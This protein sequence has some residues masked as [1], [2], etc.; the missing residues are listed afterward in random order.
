M[1]SSC[2]GRCG[3]LFLA[4]LLGTPGIGAEAPAG[5][6]VEL[7]KFVVQ[8][9]IPL[10]PPESW[11][12]A[13]GD[14]Y[15]V[16]SQ[17]SKRWTGQMVKEFLLFREVMGVVFPG[18]ESRP[19][20]P[21][22]FIFCGTRQFA[23]LAPEEKGAPDVRTLH[24]GAGPE[25]A[26]LIVDPMAFVRSAEAVAL[27]PRTWPLSQESLEIDYFR[28]LRRAYLFALFAQQEPRLPAWF[29]EGLAQLVMGMDYDQ[30]RITFGELEEPTVDLAPEKLI[31]TEGDRMEPL[32]R[33]PQAVSV[34]DRDF[35]IALREY[36]LQPLPVIFAM[37]RESPA[38]R[39][40]YGNAWGKQAAAFVHLGLYGQGRRFQKGFLQ[41]LQRS[42][43]VA[44]TEELFRECFGM[45]YDQMLKELRIYISAPVYD[46]FDYKAKDA[47]LAAPKEVALREATPGEIGRIKGETM[48]LAG[49]DDAGR[50]E[51]IAAYARGSRDPQLLA[52]L[53]LM[54]LELDHAERARRFLEAAFSAKAVRA[55]AQVELARLRLAETVAKPA[56]DGKLSGEQAAFVR[57]PLL[58]ARTQPEPPVAT[59]ELFADVWDRAQE[60]PTPS[61]LVLLEEGVKLY[62]QRLSL[63]YR[64]AV[65]EIRL[66]RREQA[67]LLIAHGLALAA[68]EAGKARFQALR[69]QL[70][71][72]GK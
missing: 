42:A 30:K 43:Q 5:P 63:V 27:D 56:V 31:G 54:E 1:A 12:Y 62:P 61:Q 8:D 33:L 17:V 29:E 71:P 35:Q 13:A 18:L 45:G 28:Q 60:G 4:S 46:A 36:R 20:R 25:N 51:M 68:S 26:R 69:A 16:L 40:P 37:S 32:E 24:F 47:G 66:G 52:A 65:W 44:P 22:I 64:T 3:L 9:S 49:R 59:Y 55:R 21:M 58:L 67:E 11:E 7:P 2:L 72:A 38:A 48:S 53:G 10:P 23:R 34:Q 50:L 57:Q 41:F 19:G 15:E 6:A 14:G 39:A 70:A